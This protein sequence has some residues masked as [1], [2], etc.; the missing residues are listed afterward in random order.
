MNAL[1]R[2]GHVWDGWPA[3]GKDVSCLLCRTIARAQ[4]IDGKIEVVYRPPWDTCFHA[5]VECF[6][7]LDVE[8]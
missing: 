4:L 3:I 7:T 6:P 1:G 5:K 2:T 8:K